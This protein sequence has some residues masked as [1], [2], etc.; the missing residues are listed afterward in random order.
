MACFG[1]NCKIALATLVCHHDGGPEVRYI[2]WE[3]GYCFG[4]KD[5]DE[6]VIEQHLRLHSVAV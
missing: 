3:L 1:N 4:M 2:S 5:L 6:E